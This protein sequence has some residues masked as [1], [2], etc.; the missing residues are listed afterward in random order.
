MK[1]YT[2]LS[3]ALIIALVLTGWLT[4]GYGGVVAGAAIG[5]AVIH[6]DPDK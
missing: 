5:F 4:N 6:L 2:P 3:I 1:N